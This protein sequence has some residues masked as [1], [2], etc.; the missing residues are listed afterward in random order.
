MIGAFCLDRWD[1]PDQQALIVPGHTRGPF[2][3]R[4]GT[5]SAYRACVP[6][7]QNIETDGDNWPKSTNHLHSCAH[8]GSC[9]P[10]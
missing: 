10:V 5:R 9:T 7:V 3:C 2:R 1:Y 8:E 4:A 6:R